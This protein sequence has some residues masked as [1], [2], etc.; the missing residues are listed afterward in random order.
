M[1]LIF[2]R[3]SQDPQTH[4]LVIGVGRFPLLKGQKAELM[5][6]LRDIED[7]TS[8]P[9]N[10]RKIAE[11]LIEA[12][13]QLIPELG[14]IELLISEEDGSQALFPRG[15]HSPPGRQNDNID[16]AT[17]NNVAQAL[18]DWMTR[19]QISANNMALFYASSHGMQAQEHVLLLEDAGE[20][21]HDPW[22]NMISL[23]H[24]HRNLYKKTNNRS[25]LFADCCRN[26]L[27]EGAH[28]LDGFTG[29]RIDTITDVE[30]V[31]ARSNP[32]RFVYML[33]AS[34]LGAEATATKNGL[35][36]FTESLL[37]CLRGGAGENN[38]TYGWCISPE[39]LR[40]W[41]E[42]AGR[43]GLGFADKHMRPHDEDANWDDVPILKLQSEPKY[44]VRV[45]EA[46]P[47]DIGRATLT[48]SHQSNAFFEQRAPSFGN[49]PALYVWA[50]PS[51]E[52]Y[53][54]EGVIP[55]AAGK[56][57]VVL[58][59]ASVKVIYTGHDVPLRR[60]S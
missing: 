20:E 56:P 54:A 46:E 41:V 6:E 3:P 21:T 44:P 31:R 55:G 5:E 17:G 48:L 16:P 22:R 37:T 28:S 18:S 2:E 11:W 51:F 60:K 40:R 59:S 45:R 24:L 49:P 27:E 15:D 12:S 9:N 10:A 32:N 58:R 7:V 36:H 52:N 8:P 29:R 19:S 1:T 42:H 57:N 26:L 25:V 33:R 53:E 13:D 47:I 30:Y 4:A 34:P 14:S 38:P 39:M 50:P 43:F 35:G 23:D